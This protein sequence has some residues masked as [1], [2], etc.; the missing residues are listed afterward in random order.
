[1]E[2]TVQNSKEKGVSSNLICD[3]QVVVSL[4][5]HGSRL[6]DVH[7]AIESIMQGTIRPNKIILWIS[8]KDKSVALPVY[9]QNQQMRGLEIKYC[10]DIRSYTKLIPALQQSCYRY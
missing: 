7:L 9:L 3:K 8:E 1:M 2:K 6:Y 10:T 5:T 4:T